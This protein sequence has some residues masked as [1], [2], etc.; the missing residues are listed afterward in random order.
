[1][2]KIFRFWWIVTLL[3]WVL[4]KR[5]EVLGKEAVYCMNMTRRWQE[6]AKRCVLAHHEFE[7][8]TEKESAE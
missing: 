2:A 3:D 8:E 1:M 4:K 5:G 6:R 7:K